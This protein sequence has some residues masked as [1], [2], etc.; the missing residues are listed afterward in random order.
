MKIAVDA[1]GGDYAPKVVIQ[2]VAEAVRDYGLDILL[3][4]DSYKIEEEIKKIKNF[5]R[6]KV[7]IIHTE[8]VVDMDDSP[9]AS[10]RKKKNS[11]ISVG[12]NLIKS[13]EAEA[14]VSAGNTGA[15]VCAATLY[16]GLLPGIER[17]GIA[18]L[19]PT[20]KGI[21]LVVD[22]GA[23]IDPKPLHLL[24]YAIMAEAYY[25]YVLNHKDRPTVGLLNVGEE[26]TKGTEFVKETHHL[27]SQSKLNFIGNVEGKEIF[28]GNCNIIVCDGYVGNVALK[29]TE[30]VAEMLKELLRRAILRGVLGKIGTLLLIRNL[31]KFK[32]D[33]DYSEYG[34]APLLGV[35]GVVIIG[36][37]RSSSKAIK[38]AIRA[39]KTE[40]EHRVN[41]QIID[42]VA[43]QV[44]SAQNSP[45]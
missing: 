15:A 39:A 7:K 32:K 11:S 21:S 6:D 2:G 24:Q 22:V 25:R 35:N 43:Q 37:G 14:F 36:H 16:L 13:K 34:G 1:M 29:V 38:N 44:T 12:I 18:I 20:L 9:T 19:F 27:L 28:S 17:P 8:E 33:L 30:S 5:P 26:A 42:I 45:A 40:V 10:V 31:K 4:G 23:N 3:V 41:E